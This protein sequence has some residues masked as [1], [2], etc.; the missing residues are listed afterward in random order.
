MGHIPERP[1]VRELLEAR[2]RDRPDRP[3]LRF[4][5][6]LIT[7]AELDRRVNR[8]A[9]SLA[10][11]GIGPGDRVPLMLPNH[12]DHFIAFFALMKLGAVQVPV[13]VNLR[14]FSLEYLLEHSDPKVVI[15]DARYREDLMPAL[16][17]CTAEAVIWRGGGDGGAALVFDFAEMAASGAEGLPPGDPQPDDV[18]AISYTSGTT[19]PPKGVLVTDKM[20]RCSAKAASLVADV[21]AGDVMFIWEPLYHIGG[22]QVMVLALEHD[23]SLALVERFSASR[24]WDQVR[25]AKAT[26]IHYLGGILQ[27]LLKQPERPGDRDNPVRVAWGGGAPITVWQPFTDRFGPEI[28]ENYGMT[29]AS[30]VT[31]L[32]LGESPEGSNGKAAPYFEVRIGDDDGNPLGVGERGEIM[33]REK[34][35]GLITKGYFRDEA[36][37]ER[38][39]KDGWLYTGDLAYFDEDENYFFIGRKK[40]SIRR[41]GENVSAWEV[42]RHVNTHS[43]VEE[44]AVIGV[45]T[46]IGEQ[47]IKLFVKVQPGRTVDPLDL[48]RWCE[49][50]LAYFQMPRYIDFVDEFP[51]TATFRIQKE[52]L[53]KGVAKSWDLN[54]SGYTIERRRGA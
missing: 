54:T 28:R 4:E 1:T 14:G 20:Y 2:A 33:V 35:P 31:T 26:Q 11:I 43:D 10:G 41:R 5:G 50:G 17:K 45:D 36:A 22:S 27:I 37:T 34:E 19:G 38:T 6:E 23:I 53:E 40:D 47:D 49:S 15:A 42:E 48:I 39:L 46:E 44:C 12:P 7:Y 24:F 52:K 51:K 18:V 25:E 21:R 9:N 30:S 32:N 3:Y 29:E 16:A 8:L 13:N